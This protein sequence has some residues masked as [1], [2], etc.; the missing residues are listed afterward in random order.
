M[1]ARGCRRKGASC[2]GSSLSRSGRSEAVGC[3]VQQV[4]GDQRRKEVLPRRCND[5]AENRPPSS[6]RKTDDGLHLS[7]AGSS[8]S[9]ATL[10]P[11]PSR[12][13]NPEALLCPLPTARPSSDWSFAADLAHCIP[14][15]S[16]SAATH[17]A[18]LSSLRY[19]ISRQ[20]Q[21]GTRQRI[22]TPSAFIA[23]GESSKQRDSGDDSGRGLIAGC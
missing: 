15:L 20:I 12:P 17:P 3:S 4:C 21:K 9:L 19:L 10:L 18:Q 22:T 16:C 23:D 7:V 13:T 6:R 5:G 1:R 14:R 8:P 11:L 2:G